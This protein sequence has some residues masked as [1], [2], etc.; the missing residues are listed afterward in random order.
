MHSDCLLHTGREDKIC[1][2]VGPVTK[3]V[4]IQRLKVCIA[5]HGNPF[6]SYGASLVIWTTQCYL[7]PDTSER[8]LTPDR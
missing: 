4:D 2:T 3:T 6:Q 1:V 7:P 8:A 5:L